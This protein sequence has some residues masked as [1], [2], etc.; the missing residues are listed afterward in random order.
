MKVIVDYRSKW[1]KVGYLPS[2]EAVY[3]SEQGNHAKE[4]GFSHLVEMTPAELKSI[5]AE[6]DPGK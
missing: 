4:V 2:G 6:R 1:H 5:T 3:F